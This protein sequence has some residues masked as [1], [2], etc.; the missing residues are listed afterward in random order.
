LAIEEFYLFSRL[1]QRLSGKTLDN[2]ENV[3]EMITEILSEP[4][5]DEVQ[6]AFLHWAERSQWI[7]DNKGEWPPN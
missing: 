4:P 6:S 3:L 1:T 7:A 5:K 2:E